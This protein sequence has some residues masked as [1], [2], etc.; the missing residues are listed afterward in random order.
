MLEA[1]EELAAEVGTLAACATLGVSRATIY[2]LR[3]PRP[4]TVRQPGPPP[5][6]LGPEEVAR[7]LDVLHSE[8]FVD[9][10]PAEIVATLLDEGTYLC[11]ERTMYRLLTEADE[12]R[13]RRSVARHR[14]YAAP[15]LVAE[16]PNQVWSWD[17]TKLKGPG[18]WNYFCLYVIL[19]IFSRYVPG[20]MVALRESAEL[21]EDLIAATCEKQ[22]I[23]P[24]QLTV[25]ADR[26]SAMTSK[27]VAE[28]L[29]DLDVAKTHSR[30][31]VSNDNPFSEA[32]FKTLKYRPEF[33]ERFGSEQDARAFCRVLTDWYNNEH[34]HSG[35]CM[36][37]PATVHYGQAEAALEHRFQVMRQAYAAHPER[38]SRPPQRQRLPE[39]VWIN[40]PHPEP[41]E[42]DGGRSQAPPAPPSRNARV[43]GMAP[44]P[45]GAG[46]S[47]PNPAGKGNTQSIRDDPA[48][49]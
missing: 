49:D 11:S 31:H 47:A 17:I 2:R 22:D 16:R 33:P 37:T 14:R 10:A 9:V 25:H 12:V 39:R 20:W 24:G 19:D 35:I 42:R 3:H 27:S 46:G 1:A 23:A 41:A 7:I 6:A 8:R 15:E 44:S 5:W 4:R 45:A 29:V 32:Q 30:P 18:K 34:R 36:L 40:P 43:Q 26:G 13:E 21:A 48:A 28:L 38:F